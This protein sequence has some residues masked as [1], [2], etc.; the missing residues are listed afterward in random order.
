M[1]SLVATPLEVRC[2]SSKLVLMCQ[3]RTRENRRRTGG[4]GF[5]HTPFCFFAFSGEWDASRGCLRLQ[6]RSWERS[7]SAPHAALVTVP[8]SCWVCH[9]RKLRACAPFDA[10][11]CHALAEHNKPAAALLSPRLMLRG[12]VWCGVMR[13][14]GFLQVI[15][16]ALLSLSAEEADGTFATVYMPIVVEG[17]KR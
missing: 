6:T 4:T 2:D 15:S 8:V 1:S 14:A 16:E 11:L 7:G 13:C 17:H 10:T 9:K 3:T 12:V 5:A